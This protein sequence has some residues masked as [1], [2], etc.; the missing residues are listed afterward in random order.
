M[1]SVHCSG[2]LR[3]IACRYVAQAQRLQPLLFWWA[4]RWRPV[5]A[6]G[7]SDRG[8]NPQL[9]RRT[10]SFQKKEISIKPA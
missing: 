2:G 10:N 1:V 3:M 4:R 7:N 6:I 5:A 9:R 8:R